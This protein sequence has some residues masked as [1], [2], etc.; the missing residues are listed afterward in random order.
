MSNHHPP[1]TG[2]FTAAAELVRLEASLAAVA[3]AISDPD[4]FAIG[5][6]IG[7]LR[8]VTLDQ[9]LKDQLAKESAVR[10]LP[11][12]AIERIVAILQSCEYAL[13]SQIDLLKRLPAAAPAAPPAT[14]LAINDWAIEREI[15]RA[16]DSARAS[17]KSDSMKES[18]IIRQVQ[19]IYENL[20]K[21]LKEYRE[22]ADLTLD[23]PNPGTLALTEK[24][25]LRAACAANTRV[26]SWWRQHA[27]DMEWSTL[28]RIAETAITLRIKEDDEAVAARFE[29]LAK[30]FRWS[31][32][33]TDVTGAPITPSFAYAARLSEVLGDAPS[34]QEGGSSWIFASHARKYVPYWLD[35]Y[36]NADDTAR[37]DASKML[38][39][40]Q[41]IPR[42]AFTR[43]GQMVA[44]HEAR[45]ETAARKFAPRS[46]AASAPQ[47]TRSAPA[48]V[49]SYGALAPTA[50]ELPHRGESVPIYWRDTTNKDARQYS[51]SKP[52][53]LTFEDT[54]A[55]REA[56]TKAMAAFVKTH[57]S[58]SPPLSAKFPL[59]PGTA[60]VPSSACDKCG[61][62]TS[63][64]HISLQ[65]SSNTP[66]PLAERN[67]RRI[68]RTITARSRGV[69]PSWL[70]SDKKAINMIENVEELMQDHFA[71]FYAAEHSENE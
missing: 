26:A 19:A 15:Q 56:Y 64:A 3:L 36:V 40:I 27:C 43:Y 54:D 50:A 12:G 38:Q 31:D 63:P 23:P 42:D 21:R 35:S 62:L 41:A 71:F 6:A 48:P 10:P 17:V 60:A 24:I 34:F 39:R 32:A 5:D 11:D 33:Y 70:N 65:C 57:G 9:R 16:K 67:Y 51:T 30:S 59:S 68:W 28:K 66:V 7:S 47:V 8:S 44:D 58:T 14:G 55:G 2:N 52:S 13:A 46:G 25:L 4:P 49:S 61:M 45:A 1:G 18:E 29:E 22:G 37:Q 69:G 20:P 53:A